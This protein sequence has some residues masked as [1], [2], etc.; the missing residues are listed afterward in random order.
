V[1]GCVIHDA[2]SYED[3][4]WGYGIILGNSSTNCLIE[5]NI[6]YTL[7]H[8]MAAVT[9]AN[10]N[11]FAYNYST[12]PY[13]LHSVPGPDIPYRDSDIVLHGRFPFANLFEHNYCVHI[14]ADDI[15][16]WNGPLN[17]FVR[18]KVYPVSPLS[19]PT[20]IFEKINEIRLHL[21]PQSAALGCEV[22]HDRFHVES[23]TT[24][25]AE[26]YGFGY[27][28]WKSHQDMEGLNRSQ[29]VL[30]DVSY[31]YSA[32]PDFVLDAGFHFPSIG[33]QA[34]GYDNPHNYNHNIPARQRDLDHQ[35]DLVYPKKEMVY[36]PD[37]MPFPSG[38]PQE[39]QHNDVE[40]TISLTQQNVQMTLYGLDQYELVTANY[41]FDI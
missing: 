41:I 20:Q 15:H 25:S 34:N 29:F 3:G 30:N 26:Q 19:D 36:L 38:I 33:P 40:V 4:S 32:T 39:L 16:G 14:E 11:V 1:S 27:G 28:A 22:E 37:P 17:A 9:G 24:F 35:D 5:N 12:D 21:A 10:C 13:A 2:A 8:S 31:Y 18:N 6:F 23:G 7:R